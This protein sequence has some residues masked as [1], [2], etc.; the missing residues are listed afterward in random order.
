MKKEGHPDY[1]QIKVIMTNGDEFVTR[2]TLEGESLR[3]D[4]DV[5]THPAWTGN[6]GRAVQGGQATRFADRYK[7]LSLSGKRD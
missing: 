1:H 3:L 6:T 5:N 4:I 7:G 2:S